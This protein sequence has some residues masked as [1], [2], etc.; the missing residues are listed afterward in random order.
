MS[1]SQSRHV[2]CRGSQSSNKQSQVFWAGRFVLLLVQSQLSPCGHVHQLPGDHQSRCEG[3]LH[4]RN[5]A[6]QDGKRTQVQRIQPTP[7]PVCRR[8]CRRH[9]RFCTLNKRI[10]H[11]MRFLAA[12]TTRA[13]SVDANVAFAT[14][15]V[16]RRTLAVTLVA[17]SDAATVYLATISVCPFLHHLVLPQLNHF[18]QRFFAVAVHA[19]TV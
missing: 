11:A 19:I 2:C 18:V 15:P 7:A 13:V 8:E 5:Y 10:V 12:K 14:T 17:R 6:L 9:M 1:F 3:K 4:L 16:T